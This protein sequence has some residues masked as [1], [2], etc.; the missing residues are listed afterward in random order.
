M[1]LFL[2]PW[3]RN[4]RKHGDSQIVLQCAMF[5]IAALFHI[6]ATVADAQSM[7]TEVYGEWITQYPAEWWAQ[8]IMLASTL[9]II[10]IIVNGNWRWSPVLRLIGAAGHVI[11]LSAFVIGAKDATFGDFFVL[12]CLVMAGMHTVFMC[13][14]IGDLARAFGRDDA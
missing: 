9:Y 11:I 8:S 6:V 1:S 3:S 10:G 14:N 2:P 12:I 5:T 4:L 7:P 13:W